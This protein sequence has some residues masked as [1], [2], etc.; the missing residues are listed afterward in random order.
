MKFDQGKAL[1]AQLEIVKILLVPWLF[2][3]ALLICGKIDDPFGNDLVDFPGKM[4][5]RDLRLRSRVF[6]KAGR[7]WE[8]AQIIS[9]LNARGKPIAGKYTVDTGAGAWSRPYPQNE[10]DKPSLG[11]EERI[12]EPLPADIHKFGE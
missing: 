3:A 6:Q 10:I 11:E 2:N 1:S 9:E 5:D 7:G 8:G 4:L 12:N